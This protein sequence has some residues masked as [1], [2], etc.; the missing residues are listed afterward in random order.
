VKIVTLP[1]LSTLALLTCCWQQM[2]PAIAQTSPERIC[3]EL[4]QAAQPDSSI[5]QNCTSAAHL[6][7]RRSLTVIGQ[8]QVTALA[9]TAL[10]EFRFGSTRD[11]LDANARS[12][13]LAPTAVQRNA[14]TALQPTLAA[15]SQANILSRNVTVQAISL[16]TT[17]L[18]VQ[19][20]QPTQERV[21]QV[22]FTVEQ[23]IRASSQIFLQSVGAAYAV[24]NCQLLE[25]SA[26]RIALRD[27]QTQL[28]TL[29][30]DVS[31]QLG[32]LLQVTVMPLVG[33]PN[34]SN[35]GTKV[36]V[37]LSPFS[38]AAESALPPYNPGDKPE[39]QVRSQVSVTHAIKTAP[40]QKP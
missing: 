31:V 27:A 12:G 11:P 15:L 6:I 35:C 26:R 1:L 9:N 21:Q 5:A 23:S 13:I 10:V 7:G 29:A 40:E 4:N 36:A 37:P 34:V 20:D 39:V 22:V 14:E 8:G 24:N 33:P 28:V 17:R 19:I 2:S 25:R 38:F 3:A 18:L 30:A 32:E 16:Q